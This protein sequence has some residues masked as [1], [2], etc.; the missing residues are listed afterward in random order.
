M[1]TAVWRRAAR[2]PQQR[3]V[4]PAKQDFNVPIVNRSIAM[5][6]WIPSMVLAAGAAFGLGNALAGAAPAPVAEERPVVDDYFGTAVTDPYRW[7]ETAGPELQDYMKA[8]NAV[9]QEALA[10][11]AA[12]T[13]SILARL[14]E[15]SRAIPS[16]R[17]PRLIGENYFYLEIPS[18]G[19][20]LILMTRPVAGGQGRVLLDPRVFAQ[21]GKH[22]AIDYFLPSWDGKYVIVGVSLGGSE[23]STL[24]VLKSKTGKRLSESISRA[25][26]A[27]PTWDEDSRGF[28]YSRL[29]EL[30]EGARAAEKYEDMR[31]YHHALGDEPVKDIAVWGPDVN[32]EPALPKLGQ[33]SVEHL[34]GTKVLLASQT[35][36]VVETPALWRRESHGWK[37]IIGHEDGVLSIAAHGS[38][39]YVIS[40]TGAANGVLRRFNAA[41]DT[42]ADAKV[43]LPASDLVLTSRGDAGLVAAKDALY[44]HGTRDGLAVVKRVGYG[45]LTPA[46]ELALPAVGSLLGMSAD[47]HK[48]GITFGLHGWI[49]SPRIYR[50][51]PTARSFE[52]THLQLAN[53]ADFSQFSA[54]EVVVESTDGAMV[55]LSIVARK[56]VTLDGS[57]PTLL[58]AYGAYGIPNSP[59]FTTTALPWLERGGILAIAHT[60][61]GG[62]RG[63]AWHLAGMKQTKQHTIDDFIACAQYLIKEGYTSS[64]HLGIEGTSAGGIA[65]GGFLTQRPVLASAVLYRVGITDILRS[66]QRSTGTSNAAEYGSV[67]IEPEFRAMYAISPYAHVVDSTSYPA[68]MLETGANDPR[69]TSWMLTKMTARLQK[70]NAPPNPILLRVDFDAGHGL[71]SDRIQALKLKADE[72]TFLGWRLGM[73]GFDPGAT[74]LSSP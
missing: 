26:E 21:S 57:N 27:E 43:V 14:T 15:L 16:V 2:S 8:E 29:K 66:E 56:D 7:M 36:G 24:H 10:P 64:T 49:V 19:N 39:L 69:V 18:T 71:G 42:F 54:R 4:R 51:D 32:A 59:R 40:K 53:P 1:I 35:T 50:Y 52:D 55:P 11:Y 13:A 41:K 44:V 5:T 17:P 61:G 65:V 28:H 25:Q 63:E 48:A 38:T 73:K 46:T 33:V 68:V 74:V 62:E 31:V 45:A 37:Q 58:D 3:L 60:R 6:G 20:D 12:Q 47:A 34:R 30:A 72:Y 22:A 9:T 70:A 23:S 67:K